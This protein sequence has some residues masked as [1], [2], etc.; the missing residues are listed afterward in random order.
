MTVELSG[1]QFADSSLMIDLACLAQRLRAHGS[2]LRL[3]GAQPN[4]LKLIEMVG[5]DRLPAVHVDGPLPTLA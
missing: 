1:L 3:S 4:V 5:L 2:M